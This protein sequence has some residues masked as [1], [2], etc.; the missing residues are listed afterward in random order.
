MTV[1]NKLCETNFSGKNKQTKQ[2]QH[3]KLLMNITANP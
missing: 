1:K 2:T 3:Y